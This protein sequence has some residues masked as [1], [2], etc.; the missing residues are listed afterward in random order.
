VSFGDSLWQYGWQD[1]A[2]GA[3]TNTRS[4]GDYAADSWNTVIKPVNP[5][6]S[7]DIYNPHQRV[8]DK[9][10]AISDQKTRNAALSALYTVLEGADGDFIAVL[11]AEADLKSKEAAAQAASRTL[12]HTNVTF[13]NGTST[14]VDLL[15]ARAAVESAQNA[16]NQARRS[17]S[18]ARTTLAKTLGVSDPAALPALEP[19]DFTA[20]GGLTAS[21]APITG[22]DE[23]RVVSALFELYTQKNPDYQNTGLDLD[24]TKESLAAQKTK[25]QPQ[26]NLNVGIPAPTV[27]LNNSTLDNPKRLSSSGSMVGVSPLSLTL[28]LSLSGSGSLDVWKTQNSVKQANNNLAKARLNYAQALSDNAD[29]VQQAVFTLAGNAADA[30]S[31]EKSL[32]IAQLTYNYQQELFNLNQLSVKD[33]RDAADTLLAAETSLNTARYAFFTQ[34]AALRRLGVFDSVTD[35]AAWVAGAL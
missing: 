7:F 17:L 11:R 31:M 6:W 24:S 34:L 33:L 14:Q 26:L 8:Q 2:Q 13:Q 22:A 3:G 25:Y 12:D 35:A 32:E 5:S 1:S 20:F 27:T 9:I 21:L 4:Y 23:R 29:T 10:Q 19:V 15:N 18:Q 30:V 28:T 16:V